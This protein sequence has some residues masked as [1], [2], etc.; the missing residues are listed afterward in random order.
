MSFT[1][2]SFASVTA[3]SFF[4]QYAESSFTSLPSTA[5]SVWKLRVPAIFHLPSTRWRVAFTAQDPFQ[6]PGMKTIVVQLNSAESP[7]IW[8]SQSSCM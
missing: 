2:S 1:L 3:W 4:S 6:V 5:S 8:I 7:R